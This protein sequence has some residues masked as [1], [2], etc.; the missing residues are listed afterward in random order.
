MAYESKHG[1]VQ[2][3][4]RDGVGYVILDRPKAHNAL[5]GDMQWDLNE[6]W[7]EVN[8]NRKVQVVVVTGRGDVF[9]DCSHPAD[10]DGPID[11]AALDPIRAYERKPDPSLAK[12]GIGVMPQVQ[13]LRYVG[14]P[15]RLAGRPAK[16][17]ITA[18]NGTCSGLALTFVAYGDIVICSS[19]AEFFAV[20][21]NGAPL[22]ET[23]TM[24]HLASVRSH[25]W[26]RMAY[27]GAKYKV[28]ADR[29][30]QLGMVA[31]VVPAGRLMERAADL[32]DMIKDASPAAVRAVV[33]AYWRTISKPYDEA[34]M[35]APLDA[36]QARTIDGKEGHIAWDEGRAPVWP[37]S[38]TFPW[39]PAWPPKILRF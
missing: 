26:L 35:I 27:M 5:N 18:I 19:D 3:Q 32:A 29:A 23:L 11:P 31:E 21:D 36:Q 20:K 9:S 15:D 14:L 24:V 13:G 38:T 28:K 17:M 16:P 6:V 25:E 34:R 10:G 7:P 4:V 8:N 33:A 30:F 22:E 1:T 37:S 12:H 39:P 2:L